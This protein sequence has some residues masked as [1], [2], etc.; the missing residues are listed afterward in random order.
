MVVDLQPERLGAPRKG[1]ADAAHADDAEP[2]AGDPAPQ[3]PGRRPSGPFRGG[4]RPRP[5]DDAA[6]D[7][8]NERHRHI[9]CVLGQ[10]AWRVGDGDA[11][12]GGGGDVDVVDAIAEIGDQL[13]LLAGKANQL[14]VDAVGDGRNQHVGG[15]ERSCEFAPRHRLVVDVE[16]GVEQFAHA[17]FDDVGQFARD[18]HERFLPGHPLSCPPATPQIAGEGL[19]RALIHPALTVTG[20][21]I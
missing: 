12:F 13:H 10:D 3:H 15:G 1:L 19:K 20:A 4:D 11:A 8:E 9:R 17:R 21:K 14:R 5:L 18:D 16:P 6:R 2:L 7:G